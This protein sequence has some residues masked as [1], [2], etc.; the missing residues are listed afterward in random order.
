MPSGL[1]LTA[2]PVSGPKFSQFGPFEWQQGS[3]SRP[4][5]WLVSSAQA[6]P[7]RVMGK[8]HGN[9]RA[10]QCQQQANPRRQAATWAEV[11]RVAAAGPGHGTSRPGRPA[12]G[13]CPGVGA[14]ARP[15]ESEPRARP[16]LSSSAAVGVIHPRR[17][18]TSRR[19]AGMTLRLRPAACSRVRFRLA[20]APLRVPRGFWFCV[21]GG[22]KV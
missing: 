16:S 17:P 19:A 20:L 5:F 6:G 4:A 9:E 12:G 18:G 14:R 22:R 2:A 21:T 7:G 3:D 10:C 8:F 15:A 1:G 13:K 11:V